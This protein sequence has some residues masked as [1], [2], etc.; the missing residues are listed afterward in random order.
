LRMMTRENK[1]T[2]CLGLPLLPGRYYI[3]NLPHHLVYIH[4]ADTTKRVCRGDETLMVS[5][6]KYGRFPGGK[7]FTVRDAVA[8]WFGNDIDRDLSFPWTVWGKVNDVLQLH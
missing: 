7:I 3:C 4:R 5:L 6:V 8:T 2:N 1:R